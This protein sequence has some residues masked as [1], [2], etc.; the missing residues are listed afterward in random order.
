MLRKP[1]GEIENFFMSVG[2]PECLNLWPTASATTAKAGALWKGRCAF[3][4]GRE[5]GLCCVIGL[6][7]N[8]TVLLFLFAEPQQNDGE[9]V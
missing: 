9:V 3:C 8:S 2:W 7:L 1:A 5:G 4:M 6:F